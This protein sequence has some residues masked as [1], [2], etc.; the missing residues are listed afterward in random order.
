MNTIYS[1][2]ENLLREHGSTT[3]RVAKAT[4]I[5]KSTFTRWRER[6]GTPTLENLIKIADYFGVSV[7]V[8]VEAKRK[9][10]N[11]ESVNSK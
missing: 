10:I 7:D 9:E 1:I 3:Y 11:N 6:D 4:G 8:F 2:Y 5:N